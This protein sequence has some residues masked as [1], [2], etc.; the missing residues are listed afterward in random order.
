MT[1]LQN[2]WNLP[3]HYFTYNSLTVELTT[4]KVYANLY[5]CLNMRILCLNFHVI[6]ISEFWLLLLSLLIYMKN[7]F[8]SLK[9]KYAFDIQTVLEGTEPTL[10]KYLKWTT[11]WNA[12]TISEVHPERII[13][14]Y[15][16]IFYFVIWREKYVFMH[17]KKFIRFFFIYQ[18]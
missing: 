15:T 1:T 7:I 12:H 16:Y 5:L 14:I 18:K 9:K 17:L 11:R 6:A 3:S 13:L 4:K 10:Y 8:V 2:G